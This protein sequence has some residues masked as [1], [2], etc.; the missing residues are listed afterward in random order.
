M[1]IRWFL[2]SEPT[3]IYVPAG[4]T[5]CWMWSRYLRQNNRCSAS[6]NAWCMVQTAIGRIRTPGHT[7][8]SGIRPRQ[9]KAYWQWLIGRAT[10][11]G[12]PLPT[13][14]SFIIWR[15]RYRDEKR[16]GTLARSLLGEIGGW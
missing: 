8:P 7:V 3:F 14:T 9:L 5:S 4:I 6:T 16:H 12:Y 1:V 13:M 15:K 10:P 2:G 11:S